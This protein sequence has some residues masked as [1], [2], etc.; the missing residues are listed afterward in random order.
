MYATVVL[1]QYHPA[2]L[3]GHLS[4]IHHLYGYLK[5]YTSTSIKFSTETTAYEKIKTIEGHWGNLYAG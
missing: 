1:S 4:N 3:K 2:P 5:K